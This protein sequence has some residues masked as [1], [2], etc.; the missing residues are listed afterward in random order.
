MHGGEGDAVVIGGGLAGMLVVRAL[1][2]HVRKVTVVERDRYPDG[3][4]FRKGVPQARHLHILLTGGQE[5]LEELLPGTG[6]ELAAAGARRLDMPRDLLT[7]GL[8]GWQIRFHEGRHSL[9]SC[10]RPL[11]DHVVRTRVLAAA[12]ASGT[13]V[14]V[15]EA[16]DAVGLLGGPDRV[17]GVRV[18]PRGA[19][20]QERDMDADLVVDASGRASRTPQWLEALGRA[21][22][23]QESVDPGLQYASRVLRLPEPPGTGVYVQYRPDNPA[24]GGLL[25]LEDGTWILTVSGIGG[26]DVPTDEDGFAEFTSGLA[27]PYLHELLR[28]A[29]PLS[30]VI[31]F[32]DTS[33]RRRRYEAPGGVPEGLV[34]V[35][36]AACSFNP[37]YGQGMTVAAVGALALR[38]ALADGGPRAGLAARAQRAVARAADAA[39]LTAVGADR[40]Y[41]DVGQSSAPGLGE[42]FTSW[43]VERLVAR[44]AVDPVVGSA[45][46]DVVAL[47][48]PPS[49]MLAP[50]VALRT[51]LLRR[52]PALA[53]PPLGPVPATRR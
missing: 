45:F 33:N 26:L 15:V 27:H 12:A 2:G 52:R 46:R 44:A 29:E 5:A 37:V 40:P 31:G 8:T 28:G 14:E 43:Y 49:R 25:P 51:M 38:D 39:W 36:D 41:V 9:I 35:G 53:D 47:T 24:A 42:R 22:P 1:L 13:A 21:A 6:A 7:C 10:T 18:R 4:A 23:A 30:P 48:A 20:R 17:T 50:A 16:T 19:G 3:P 32:R 34:V 11:L